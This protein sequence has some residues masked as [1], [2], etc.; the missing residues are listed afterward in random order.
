MYC[1]RSFR[2]LVTLSIF[3][4]ILFPISC[5]KENQEITSETFEELVKKYNL[6]I[7]KGSKAE[8]FKGKK[9]NSIQEA[10]NY[11]KNIRKEIEN[12][13]TFNGD[14]Q[15]PVN[16]PY[17]RY[18]GAV[19][20]KHPIKSKFAPKPLKDSTKALRFNSSGWVTDLVTQENFDPLNLATIGRIF[21]FKYCTAD[22]SFAY[23]G[24]SVEYYT[25]WNPFF[26]VENNNLVERPNAYELHIVEKYRFGVGGE[27]GGYKVISW[28]PWRTSTWNFTSSQIN[29]TPTGGTCSEDDDGSKRSIVFLTDWGTFQ[30]MCPTST[31]LL[32]AAENEGLNL[33]SSCKAGACATCTGKVLSGQVDQMDG[34]FLTDAQMASGYVSLCVAYPMT[35]CIIK[36]HAE[37]ELSYG[38]ENSKKK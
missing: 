25:A 6:E 7:V 26:L 8:G 22:N 11:F 5:K 24:H 14:W 38:N 34:S 32:E 9:F 10:D 12:L 19:N 31:F 16:D 33:P 18:E 21:T 27:L 2:C 29:N 1:K 37:S 4:L 13:S 3:I 23:D 15:E 30:I 36:T 20:R 35:D 28:Q 17:A